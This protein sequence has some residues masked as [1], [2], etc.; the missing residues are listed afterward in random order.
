MLE[1]YVMNDIPTHE[2]PGNIVP[3]S[4]ECDA[5]Q[6]EIYPVPTVTRGLGEIGVDPI[7]HV[8]DVKT[9]ADIP[10]PNEIPS[11]LSQ[12]DGIASIHEHKYDDSNTVRTKA[13]EAEALE[14]SLR[15]PDQEQLLT[16]RKAMKAFTYSTA[17]E[18]VYSPGELHGLVSK[19]QL[20]SEKNR[21]D[22]NE[23]EGEILDI[24][25][26]ETARNRQGVPANI[27]GA[28]DRAR[29]DA[30]G[31]RGMQWDSL[32]KFAKF[33]SD[34]IRSHMSRSEEREDYL[35]SLRDP[36]PD[37]TTNLT[38]VY[39]FVAD[40]YTYEIMARRASAVSE[41]RRDAFVANCQLIND[42]Y[43]KV[44]P[45]L[46]RLPRTIKIHGFDAT[47][48][49]RSM[50]ETMN[51]RLSGDESRGVR[52][53]YKLDPAGAINLQKRIGYSVEDIKTALQEILE[54][55]T[56]EGEIIPLDEE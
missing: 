54:P 15:T 37:K 9:D 32:I 23:V 38:A 50:V 36:E 52:K 8:T 14:P 43:E 1:Y 44:T 16:D 31:R 49:I 3:P 26:S 48:Q 51:A 12:L 33:G 24:A 25:I 2:D 11:F 41:A 4:I 18:F 13:E 29:N 10:T 40:V 30:S 56:D 27:R 5:Q 35:I 45:V 17:Y 42:W 53:D 20:L 39:Q 22:F 47:S 7:T 28:A 6:A 46:S 34:V 21:P 55:K 19:L